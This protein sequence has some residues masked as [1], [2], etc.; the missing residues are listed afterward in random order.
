MPPVLPS[1]LHKSIISNHSCINHVQGHGK[2]VK[3]GWMDY[4]LFLVGRSGEGDWA[5]GHAVT[6]GAR[7]ES[8]VDALVKAPSDTQPYLP[9]IPAIRYS[10]I[11]TSHTSHQRLSHTYQPY[12]P[13]DTQ[14]YRVTLA[15]QWQFC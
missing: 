13:F 9:A 15:S 4:V 10:A 14:P 8:I 12:Q 2:F 5:W 3:N 11:P 7:L 6:L 1:V